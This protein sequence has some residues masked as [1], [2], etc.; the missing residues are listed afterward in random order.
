MNVTYEDYR[1]AKEIMISYIRQQIEIH[2]S[3]LATTKIKNPWDNSEYP[4]F[5]KMNYGDIEEWSIDCFV[6][7]NPDPLEFD[8]E[9]DIEVLQTK[10]KN[11]KVYLE[12]IK[13]TTVL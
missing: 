9:G 5:E 10:I 13:K 1:K 11:L 12:T 3:E 7:K 2:R 4:G 8:P 6:I